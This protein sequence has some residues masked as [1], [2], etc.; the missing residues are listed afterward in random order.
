MGGG[1]RL[2]LRGLVEGGGRWS[3]LVAVAMRERA[4]GAR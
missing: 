1:T 3:F 2:L 4:E